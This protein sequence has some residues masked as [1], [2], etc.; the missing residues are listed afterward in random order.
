V[1][2]RGTAFADLDNDGDLDVV[3]AC[4]DGVPLLLR[5]DG[6]PGHWLMLRAVGGRGSNKDAI[7]ARITVRTETLSQVREV[8]RTLAIY[9]ASD[10]RAHFGLGEATKADLVRVEWP[11]G[12]VDEF[13]DVP[14]DRHY[15]L[16]EAE[17]LAPEPPR[18]R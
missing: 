7:G 2:G 5:N 17:G 9:S 8:K 16:D 11:S 3:V 4:L 6:A 1:L 10:P 18:R 13:R 12:K 15:R 14:A